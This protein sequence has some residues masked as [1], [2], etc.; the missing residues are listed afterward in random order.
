MDTISEARLQLLYPPLADKFRRMSEILALDPSPTT[1]R[2]TQGLRSWGD[3][4]KLYAQGRTSPGLIVTNAPPG[5]S[6][7]EYGLAGDLAVMVN[8]EPDW[9][10]AHPAWS[11][12]VTVGESLGLTAGAHWQHPD[13]PHFQLTGSFPVSP[14]AE[15]RQILLNEG[16][17]AFWGVAFWG[18]WFGDSQGGM[19]NA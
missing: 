9:D 1:V 12:I 3:Q 2:L 6:W 10:L 13:I 19:L 5:Y 16:V 4:A 7:H 17:E 8:G 11:R 14:N 18:V 15:A